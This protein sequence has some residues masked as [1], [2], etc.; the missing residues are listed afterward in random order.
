[1][2]RENKE[3]VLLHR[4]SPSWIQQLSNDSNQKHVGKDMKRNLAF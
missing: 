4:S 2:T 3:V 1:M